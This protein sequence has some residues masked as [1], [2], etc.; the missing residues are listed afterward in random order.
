MNYSLNLLGAGWDWRD[1]KMNLTLETQKFEY[2]IIPKLTDIM[3]LDSIS[4]AKIVPFKF[5]LY[6]YNIKEDKVPYELC[7]VC[8]FVIICS[9][10]NMGCIFFFINVTVHLT[11][12]SLISQQICG[13]LKGNTLITKNKV[14]TCFIVF[15]FCA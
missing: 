12:N 1:W 13:E 4:R 7:L 6:M 9:W 2:K 10:N 15:F 8:F 3:T 5:P 14:T 11:I